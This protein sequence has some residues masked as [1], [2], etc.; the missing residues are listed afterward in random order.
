MLTFWLLVSN[1]APTLNQLIGKNQTSQALQKIEKTTNLNDLKKFDKKGLSPIHIAAEEGEYQVVKALLIRGIPHDFQD[2]SGKTALHYAAEC[3]DERA[4]NVINILSEHQANLDAR[5]NLGWTPLMN[6][7]HHA[8]LAVASR[9]LE[10]GADV[11]AKNNQGQT[12][13]HLGCRNFIIYQYQQLTKLVG[14]DSN[15]PEKGY[16]QLINLSIDVL[17]KL[18]IAGADINAT[19]FE[20]ESPIFNAISISQNLVLIQFLVNNGA[21]INIV[22][23]KGENPIVLA[24]DLQKIDIEIFLQ[25]FSVK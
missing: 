14:M 25:D 1:C 11:S 3:Y 16:N 24:K 18:L 6:A 17:K 19:D 8:R 2:N 23:L 13:L 21:K 20:G 22:N 4:V 15:L 7:A 10:L 9:L 5:D 12:V